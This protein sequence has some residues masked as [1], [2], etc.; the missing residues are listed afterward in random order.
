MIESHASEHIAHIPQPRH[1]GNTGLMLAC[2]TCR[3]PFQHP[4]F[5]GF[6][7]LRAA[8]GH[9]F[10]LPLPNPAFKLW[11]FPFG[12][13]STRR[14]VCSKKTNWQ[15]RG[16]TV[17]ERGAPGARAMLNEETAEVAAP[18]N[19]PCKP[20]YITIDEYEATD[21]SESLTGSFWAVMQQDIHFQGVFFPAAEE[22]LRAA[23]QVSKVDAM[24]K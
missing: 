6:V 2:P 17:Q 1:L 18:G 24:L 10:L 16:L 5:A 3:Q 22:P 23:S 20:K 15:A 19:G 21:F 12:Y 11:L 14:H 4:D 9:P 7:A 8:H 13:A